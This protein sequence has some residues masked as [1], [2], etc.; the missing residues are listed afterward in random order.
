MVFVD[1]GVD[2]DGLFVDGEGRIGG[3]C[4]PIIWK[5][6]HSELGLPGRMGE[7]GIEEADMISAVAEVHQGALG[8]YAH[9]PRSNVNGSLATSTISAPLSRRSIL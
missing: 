2:E 9:V 6:G 3:D 5:G 8:D 7:R 1:N 4:H